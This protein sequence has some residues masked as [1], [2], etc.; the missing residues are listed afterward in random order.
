MPLFNVPLT[1]YYSFKTKDKEYML[2]VAGFEKHN[3]DSDNLYLMDSD[4]S[5][6]EIGGI[7]IKRASLRSLIHGNAI[8]ARSSKTNIVGKLKKS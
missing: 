1:G 4:K 2:N 8:E 3:N 7:I 5:K 6:A